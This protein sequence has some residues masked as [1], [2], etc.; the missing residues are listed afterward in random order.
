[1]KRL[2]LLCVVSAAG[3]ASAAKDPLADQVTQMAGAGARRVGDFKR[4][5]GQRIEWS[6]ELRTGQCYAVVGAGGDGV[7]ALALLLSDPAGKKVAFEEKGA[8]AQTVVSWCP[9]K[10]GLY[11]VQA[12]IGG[13][14][15]FRVGVFGKP[16]KSDAPAGK[17]VARRD[18]DDDRPRRRHDDDDDDDR[19]SRRR[20]RD[21]DDDDDRPRRR[22]HR[23]DDDDDDRPRRRHRDDD[24]DDRASRRR[25][26]DDDGD[27]GGNGR[28]D[29]ISKGVGVAGTIGGW[30]KSI[31]FSG[32]RTETHS[33]S[34]RTTSS[35]DGSGGGGDSGGGGG[36]GGCKGDF[37][38]GES[39]MINSRNDLGIECNNYNAPTN[40]P[41]GLYI[42]FAKPKQC[43][44]IARCG[45]FKRNPRE[46]EAC[47][48][49]GNWVC[50]HYQATS[51]STNHAVF[52]APKG[53]NLCHK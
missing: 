6:V 31:S 53:W 42:Q 36:G 43:F 25:H 49:D 41:T 14:G 17:A 8:P 18:D 29:T 50:Q 28:T 1:M 38:L 22:H 3:A 9:E 33:T 27:R 21:D 16:G 37:A 48:D 46:G 7:R 19:A 35:D 40:C 11:H 52:C 20:H 47:T 30:A 24:D 23:D 4:G 12:K 2:V 26:D 13:K 15:D 32:S 44:C 10:T 39:A 45:D 34:T 5:E 51:Y